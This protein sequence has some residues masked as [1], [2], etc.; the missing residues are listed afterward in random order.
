MGQPANG[1]L[2]P[3]VNRLLAGVAILCVLR[4]V[5]AAVLPLSA[6]EAYYWLWSKH[7][8]SG[9]FDHPPAI[10]FLIRGGTI[11]LGATSAGVRAGS[12]IA[13]LIATFFVWRSAALFLGREEDGACAALYFNLTLMV[14]AESLAATPDAPEIA[15]AAAFLYALLRLQIGG[16]GR[17]WLLAGVAGGFALLSKYTALFLGLGTGFWLVAT[18]DGRAW[19]KTVW[20][21]AGGI[22]ATLIFSP[23]LVWNSEHHWETFVFQFA[24]V[25]SG[26]FTFRFLAEFL[27]AQVGLASPFILLLTLRG[28]ATAW[29]GRRGRIAVYLILPAIAYFLIHALHDR[30]QAN[31]TSFLFPALSILAAAAANIPQE[32]R[33][34]PVTR[35]AQRLA[36]PVAV[37]L[38]T[39]TYAQAFFAVV[40]AGRSDPVSR[41]L[42]FGIGGIAAR[43][44]ALREQSGAAGFVTT[45]YATAAW[46]AFYSPKTVPILVFDDDRRWTFAD[47]TP[48]AL[49]AQPLLYVAEDR[50][51]ARSALSSGFEQVAFVG[52]IDRERGGIRIARY[53]VYRLNG[54]RAGR[55]SLR[56][57]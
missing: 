8:A 48:A 30:V 21:Y 16:D 52:S 42:G 5:A 31:W 13:S 10:A 40:P 34:A 14:S 43:A 22:L 15:S 3:T 24:R 6:D 41:L 37:F 50:H 29:V 35:V 51:D 20:P 25:G 57:P 47:Q 38:L 54:S 46:F 39:I 33:V 23:N 28:A 9:Y 32:S 26:E 7:L 53:V 36:I 44:E 2:A 19:L 17:W 55:V 49:V 18:P 4:A 27:L 11:L 56:A 45:D 1:S 12:F